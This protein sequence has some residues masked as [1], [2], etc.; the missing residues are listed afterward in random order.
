LPDNDIT[1]RDALERSVAGRLIV[2]SHDELRVVDAVL[3]RLAIGRERYGH[4]VLQDDKRDW[5]REGAEELVDTAIYRA[6]ALISKQDTDRAA[7]HEDVRSELAEV[8]N[9]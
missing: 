8:A 5:Q 7:L 1:Q 4:L 6:C 2:C 3:N 9:G